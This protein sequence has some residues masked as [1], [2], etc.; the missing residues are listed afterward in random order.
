MHCIAGD[1]AVRATNDDASDCK[2][3]AVNLGYWEDRYISLFVKAGERK[4]P[5]INRGYYART[6]GVGLL[7]EAFI[8]VI[9]LMMQ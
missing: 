5:E 4:A 9:I 7:I 2:R 1:D 6:R 3:C 8:K